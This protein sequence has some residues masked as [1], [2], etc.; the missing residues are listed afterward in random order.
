MPTWAV[1]LIISCVSP[2]FKLAVKALKNK[3]DETSTS[4]DNKLIDI[5]DV[6]IAH[7]VEQKDTTVDAY[8]QTTVKKALT[9]IAK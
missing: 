2:L 7:K 8:L 5:V 9:K 3:A 4:L 6:V 1:S